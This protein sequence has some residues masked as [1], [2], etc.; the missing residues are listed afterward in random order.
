M[1][2]NRSM[3][4]VVVNQKCWIFIL[5]CFLFICSLSAFENFPKPDHVF[6]VP[7]RDGTEL[8]T[9][10]FLP[11]NNKS[12]KLP[13]ILLRSP[14]GIGTPYALIHTPLKEQGYAVVIQAT[15]SCLEPDG[16]VFP[17]LADGWGEQQDGYDAIEWLGK[18]SFCNG[19]I[20]T[21]GTSAMGIT[22]L[23][24]APTAPPSLKCQYIR[25]AA[26]SLYH[27]ATYPGGQLLK[28]QAERWLGY[29]ARDPGIHSYV[30]NHPY[31]DSF[32][33][34]FNSLNVAHRVQAPAI[35]IGGWFDTFIQGTIDAYE[36][37]QKMGGVGAKGT[38][39]LVIGP[40]H[41]YWPMTFAFGDFQMPAEGV[42]PP[43]D[44]SP[45]H[46]FSH[47][48]QG[49]KKEELPNVIYYVMGPFDGSPSSGNKW[50][51]A[52]SWPP[53]ALETPYY[54]SPQK[55]LEK[56]PAKETSLINYTYHPTHPVPTIGG[57]NLFLE[58]GP[59]DQRE[60]EG[61]DDVIVFTSAP[62]EEDLEVTGRIK[63]ILYVTSSVKD[64]DFSVRLCDVYPDGRSILIADSTYRPGILKPHESLS[65]TD[66][67][68]VEVDL[69]STSLVFA[70]GHSL[71]VSVTSSNYPRFEKNL[72][73]GLL[74]EHSG[75][76]VEAK[77]GLHLGKDFKSRILLPIIGHTL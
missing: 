52:D 57:R 23:M 42:Q 49:I 73:L 24:L 10:L 74:G 43:Y 17:Y 6:M 38:Q 51:T 29:C 16:K 18:A 25:F 58:S 34:Q 37:R 44:V 40:W 48:L 8:P 9:A 22:Q 55:T 69:W 72:N 50:K 36:S 28:N 67:L 66:P 62:L 1:F 7:M 47:H 5:S 30:C 31:Y 33:D 4:E 12:E 60:I 53:E 65:S 20:G 76:S 68:E 63:A 26:G 15:R 39:K 11:A 21:L 27:H 77:I 70:K 54:L 61:R 41:H 59:K 2:W 35:H 71:R 13:C 14:A 3:F 46:W 45:E 64:T 75:K 56:Q 19:Q 32:W